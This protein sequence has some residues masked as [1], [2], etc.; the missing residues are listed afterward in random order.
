M[1]HTKKFSD[2]PLICDCDLQWYRNWIKGLKDKDDEM[3]Q[4]K[5]TVCLYSQDQREYS[6]Q[7]L[8]LEKM[9]C[10]I[11]SYDSLNNNGKSARIELLAPVT[12]SVLACTVIFF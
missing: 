7:S 6:L 12:L 9:N 4:K 11:K 2:N 10:V 1:I 5:R 8:P 3:M